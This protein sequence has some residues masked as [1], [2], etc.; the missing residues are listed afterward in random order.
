MG[1]LI[2]ESFVKVHFEMNR[3][4]NPN[5]QIIEVVYEIMNLIA[6]LF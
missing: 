6:K 5:E 2:V 3:D 4:L 1:S